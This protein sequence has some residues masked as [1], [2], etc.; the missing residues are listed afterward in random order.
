MYMIILAAG[1][2]SRLSPYTDKLP[3]CLVEV[4]GK[5]L[6]DWQLQTARQSNIR[7]IAVVRGF[8]ASAIDRSDVTYFEN[9]DYADTNMVETLWCASSVFNEGFIVSYG[10]IIY[11]QCVLEALLSS[12][13][14]ISVV[15]DT[16]WKDYWEQRFDNVMSDA[17]TLESNSDGTISSIGQKPDHIDQINGQ[18]IGLMMFRGS[19]VQALRQVYE[20]AK[21]SE[22][23]GHLPL[24]GQRTFRQLY[25][26]DILQGI[27]DTGF[28]VQQVPIKRS[29]LEIDTVTDLELANKVVNGSSKQLVVDA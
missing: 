4:S 6:L 15:V 13:A 11:E 22:L 1:Q 7:D 21:L 29:W 18:Y 12:S 27:V 20:N 19:G 26:T 10:D 28:P 17:E 25:M 9:L 8:M 16:C 23:S 24:R 3:K 2:G 14:A 5:T